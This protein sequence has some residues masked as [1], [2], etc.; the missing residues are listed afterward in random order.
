[1]TP[2]APATEVELEILAEVANDPSIFA[3]RIALVE[4]EPETPT[5]TWRRD[6]LV[7]EMPLGDVLDDLRD[8]GHYRLLLLVQDV[9][10]HGPAALGSE[11]TNVL[12]TDSSRET[13]RL[14]QQQ[15]SRSLCPQDAEGGCRTTDVELHRLVGRMLERGVARV[16]RCGAPTARWV[17]VEHPPSGPDGER[18]YSDLRGHLLRVPR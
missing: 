6:D 7:V 17:D 13:K 11:W 2:P 15:Q 16:Y 9:R 3:Q 5:L 14:R 4:P 12:A 10:E 8:R 18:V 1:V